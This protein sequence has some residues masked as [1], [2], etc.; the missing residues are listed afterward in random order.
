[1]ILKIL[2]VLHV[3]LDSVDFQR[4][5]NGRIFTLWLRIASSDGQS[6]NMFSSLF[7]TS[8]QIMAAHSFIFSAFDCGN[9]ESILPL[10]DVEE[11]LLVQEP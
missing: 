10:L 1:M 6:A 8:F 11:F 7:L 4:D 2:D 9:E 3:Q 5:Y